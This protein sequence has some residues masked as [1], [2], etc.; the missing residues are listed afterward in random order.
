MPIPSENECTV[1][2]TTISSAYVGQ[3]GHRRSMSDTSQS[4]LGRGEGAQMPALRGLINW[5]GEE[6]HPSHI[7]AFEDAHPYVAIAFE[8]SLANDDEDHAEQ[9][10]APHAL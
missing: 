8:H 4:C 7:H 2:T 1:I 6:A 5:Q 3:P 10:A 9:N